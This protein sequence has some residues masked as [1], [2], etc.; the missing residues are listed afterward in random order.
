MLADPS[1]PFEQPHSGAAALID[2]I[3]TSEISI[4]NPA[5]LPPLSGRIAG[6]FTFFFA[7]KS[8]RIAV[9]I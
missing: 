4:Q 8:G 5:E 1:W 3:M 6:W 7:G 2:E 9:T